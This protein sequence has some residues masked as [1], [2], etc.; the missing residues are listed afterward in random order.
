MKRMDKIADIYE[1]IVTK[2]SLGQGTT[3]GSLYAAEVPCS[4]EVLTS[5]ELEI[6]RLL[7]ATATHTV[8]MYADPNR[9][10]KHTHWLTIAGRKLNIAEVKLDDRGFTVELTCGEEVV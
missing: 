7:H 6:A 9:P 5:R 3:S 8:R 10:I 4:L 2:D 1:P